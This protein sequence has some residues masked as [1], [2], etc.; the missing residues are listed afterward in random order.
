MQT[1][2]ICE[3]K[4]E[5]ISEVWGSQFNTNIKTTGVRAKSYQNGKS[6]ADQWM[7]RCFF[8]EIRRDIRERFSDH[9]PYLIFNQE[10][11]CD[12]GSVRGLKETSKEPTAPDALNTF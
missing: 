11:T 3:I 4:A 2:L 6:E 5:M 1:S 8:L 9:F 7:S 10:K 12:P